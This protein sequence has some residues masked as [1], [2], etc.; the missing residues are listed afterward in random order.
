MLLES[1]GLQFLILCFIR[2][3]TVSSVVLLRIAVIF[4]LI[5]IDIKKN[6]EQC[7]INIYLIIGSVLLLMLNVLKYYWNLYE[8]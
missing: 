7:S 1:I 4:L 8:L 5:I 2:S 6:I 3:V